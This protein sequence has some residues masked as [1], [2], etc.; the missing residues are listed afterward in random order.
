M[1]AVSSMKKKSVIIIFFVLLV[2]FYS[3]VGYLMH[4]RIVRFDWLAEV[5]KWEIFR[6]YF[7]YSYVENALNNLLFLPT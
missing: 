5:T 3:L 1:E 6:T 2:V 4:W 7:V